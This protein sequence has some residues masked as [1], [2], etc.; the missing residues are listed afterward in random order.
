MFSLTSMFQ[1]FYVLFSRIDTFE[2]L[3]C[4]GPQRKLK[5][6]GFCFLL[7][8]QIPQRNSSQTFISWGFISEY[9]K[10][11][12]FLGHEQGIVHLDLVL[13]VFPQSEKFISSPGE[14]LPGH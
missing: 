12:V 7:L 9:S 3:A 1:I 6:T 14:S 2:L 13:I 5:V 4:L 10:M 8:D 11:L